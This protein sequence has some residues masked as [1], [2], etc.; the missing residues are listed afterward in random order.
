MPCPGDW[1]GGEDKQTTFPPQITLWGRRRLR[2]AAKTFQKCGIWDTYA[3]A[4]TFWVFFL[5]I[6][7]VSHGTIER[8]YKGAFN[9]PKLTSFFGS[10]KCEGF[11]AFLEKNHVEEQ[12]NLALPSHHL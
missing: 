10:V 4:N 7:S 9:T 2:R 12:G 3:A 8:E 5:I 6:V 1:L 11:S